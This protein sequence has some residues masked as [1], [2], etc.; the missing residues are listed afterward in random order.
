M[1]SDSGWLGDENEGAA[2]AT[3]QRFLSAGTNRTVRARASGGDG[4]SCQAVSHGGF[5][6]EPHTL[7]SVMHLLGLPRP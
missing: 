3:V 5:D 6:D 1:A 4:L 2:L 7:A